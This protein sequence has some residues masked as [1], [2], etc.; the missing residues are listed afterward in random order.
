MKNFKSTISLPFIRVTQYF[1]NRYIASKMTEHDKEMRSFYSQFTSKG[2]LVFDVGAHIGNRTR[3]F[4]KLGLE[5]IAIEPQ[6]TCVNKLQTLYGRNK[7]LTIL[8]NVLGSS[9][10][11]TEI[12]VSNAN[13]ISSL[14]HEWID[15]VKAS[16]R[17]AEY[18]WNHT[19][20]ITMT[21]LDKLIETYGTPTLIKVDVEGFEYEVIKALSK[22]VHYISL[23]FTP[24]FIDSSYKCIEH[25][26]TLGEVLFNYSLGESMK[27]ELDNYVSS[28]EIIVILES[29]RHDHVIFGDIYC[30]FIK[31]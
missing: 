28:K 27:L 29:Y 15:A 16:G 20:K 6:Y 1:R 25:L 21:T 4:L 8:Q 2:D 18:S 23:E 19:Q 24:E 26:E 14:S 17:F 3:I 7:H 12:M 22:P 5:V 9:E 30:Q 31:Y 13:T 10:G 11:E